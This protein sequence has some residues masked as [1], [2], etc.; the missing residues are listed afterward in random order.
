ME[1]QM[2]D[3]LNRATKMI[4]GDGERN[5]VGSPRTNVEQRH[6]NESLLCL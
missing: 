5:G 4:G 3:N 2:D 6:R 1:K